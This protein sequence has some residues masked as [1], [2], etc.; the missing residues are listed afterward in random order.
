M[1]I[2][3]LIL[4]FNKNFTV[5]SRNFFKKLWKLVKIKSIIDIGENFFCDVHI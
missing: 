3:F 5:I 4:F 2:Y 1:S